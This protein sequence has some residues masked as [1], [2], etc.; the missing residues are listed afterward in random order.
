MADVYKIKA[1][2]DASEVERG[3]NEVRQHLQ[4]VAAAAPAAAPAAGQAS[5]TKLEITALRDKTSAVERLTR[6]TQKLSV[7]Q[8]AS[9]ILG[10]ATAAA[11]LGGALLKARGYETGAGALTGA[12]QGAARLGTMLAPLGPQAALIGAAAGGI[13][14]AIGSLVGSMAEARKRLEEDAAAAKKAADEA[15]KATRTRRASEIISR[16]DFEE[17]SKTDPEGAAQF[18]STIKKD[19]ADAMEFAKAG[20]PIPQDLSRAALY[21]PQETRSVIRT[22]WDRGG[23]TREQ[24]DLGLALSAGKLAQMK[25]S[26]TGRGRGL[27]AT[28]AEENRISS[29][30][31]RIESSFPELVKRSMEAGSTGDVKGRAEEAGLSAT[32]KRLKAGGG[33]GVGAAGVDALQ[34]AGLGVYSNP[35]KQAETLLASIDAKMGSLVRKTQPGAV[36]T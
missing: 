28:L 8:K 25:T 35:M 33:G 6:E 10:G 11:G 9:M 7:Q 13:T 27:A 30:Q 34:A 17:L 24:K 23:L 19:I 1:T 15:E 4:I 20:A 26:A 32:T 14:G 29:I 5:A 36:L 12:A 3:A 22:G 21:Y 16:R 31:K 18:L 2:L